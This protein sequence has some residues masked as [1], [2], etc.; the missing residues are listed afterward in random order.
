MWPLSFDEDASR[1]KFEH[2][3]IVRPLIGTK[4]LK[5][6]GVI[7]PLGI[8]HEGINHSWLSEGLMR[9]FL[10]SRY[11]KLRGGEKTVTF[12]EVRL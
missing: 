12:T 10:P 7:V 5:V 9:Q 6:N 4:M 11:Q 3:R 2:G 1:H 8:D